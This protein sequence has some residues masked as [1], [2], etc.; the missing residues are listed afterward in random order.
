MF[1]H[2]FG[3]EDQ[4]GGIDF[5]LTFVFWSASV[6]GFEDG[7]IDTDVGARGNSETADESGAE[8]AEDIAIEVG[9]DKHVILFR[10]LDELHAH[11]VDESFHIEDFAAVEFCGIGSCGG[12]DSGGEFG[13]FVFGAVGIGDSASDI[14][15]KA[16]GE[17]HDVGFGDGRYRTAAVV[18]GIFEGVIGD[19]GSTFDG[20]WF[21]ADTG[22]FGAGGDFLSAGDS[23]N[24]ADELFGDG[25]AGFEFDTGVEVFGVFADDY[26]VDV[27]GFE[28]GA[29]TFVGFAGANAGVQTEFLAEKDVDAAEAFTDGSGDRGFECDAIG[30]NGF[31]HAFGDFAFGFDDFDTA[32]LD[33]PIDF[34]T[35]GF[36]TFAGCF[37]DFGAD[38]ITGEQSDLMHWGSL[39]KR[40]MRW[41]GIP[42]CTAGGE[43]ESIAEFGADG[44]IWGGRNCAAAE[45][46]NGG[47]SVGG[48]V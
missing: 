31:E 37:G 11:V 8:V 20:D 2:E 25:F 3:R 19:A 15:P 34:D 43:R 35:S 28:E 40:V 10:F 48:S 36:D 22:G 7:A 26:E 38:T 4:R 5:I 41:A 33:V 9:H 14:V 18:N 45:S 39:A 29:D 12:R 23:I 27:A 16:I 46:G 21:D 1:E 6:G 13:P 32:F 42:A 30:A 44:N 47:G 24:L 17:L